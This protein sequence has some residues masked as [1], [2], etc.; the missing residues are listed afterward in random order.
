MPALNQATKALN[1]A[2]S[3]FWEAQYLVGTYIFFLFFEVQIGAHGNGCRAEVNVGVDSTGATDIEVSANFGSPGAQSPAEMV[4]WAELVQHVAAAACR[5]EAY[6]KHQF[7]NGLSPKEVD[8]WVAEQQRIAAQKRA[9][10]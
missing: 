3:D 7:R 10:R 6:L 5:V 8:E 4:V 2:H 1:A 9:G